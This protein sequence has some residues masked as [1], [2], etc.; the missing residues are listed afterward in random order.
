MYSISTKLDIFFKKTV[1]KHHIVQISNFYGPINADKPVFSI[2]SGD[3]E[4]LLSFRKQKIVRQSEFHLKKK[5]ELKLL[6]F[7]A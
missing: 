2:F 1:V 3:L 5:K 7:S 6:W 4:N